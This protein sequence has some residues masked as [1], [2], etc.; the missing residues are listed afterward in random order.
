MNGTR[1]DRKPKGI[2]L[3]RERYLGIAF[4]R[5][6]HDPGSGLA[7]V[8]AGRFSSSILVLDGVPVCFP[9]HQLAAVLYRLLYAS[10]PCP[11]LATTPA[12]RLGPVDFN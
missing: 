12:P 7:K 8:F 1:I 3:S 6:S 10:L 2:G 9:V 5:F 11:Q 4:S